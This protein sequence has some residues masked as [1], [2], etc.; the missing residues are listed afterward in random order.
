MAYER[1]LRMNRGSLPVLTAAWLFLASSCSSV[2]PA[3]IG[4][5]PD[6]A[7]TPEQPHG[8]AIGH[9]P[10][11]LGK[12]ELPRI[13]VAADGRSFESSDGHP[14]VPFGVTY[15][16]PGTGWA[17]QVWKQFD[18]DA[19]RRDFA[20]MKRL[21]VNCVRV[22][23]TYGSFYRKP[24]ELDQSGLA[25]FD[26]LL[27]IAEQAGI[28]IHPTGPDHWEG[29][30]DWAQGDRIA[31]EGKLQALES[32][33]RLFAAKYQGRSVIFAY[34][35]LNEPAV[36]WDSEAMRKKWPGWLE[37]KHVSSEALAAAHGHTGLTFATAPIPGGT[38][39]LGDRALLDFQEFRESLADD[40]TA[41]QVGAIRSVDRS[42]LVTVGLIQWSVP[43][44][45]ASPKHYSGFR[46]ARQA[47][48]LD[49]LE[50]HFYPF[51]H[52]AYEYGDDESE[53]RNL[54]Y[55]DSVVREVARPGKPVVL[56]EFGW[57]GGGRPRFD[58]G[59]HPAATEEQQARWCRKVI[60]GTR[61]LA[62]G[63]LTWGL[64]DQPEATDVSEFTGL[65][66]GDGGMKAWG[67]EF[68]ELAAELKR[69]PFQPSKPVDYPALNWDACLT[70]SDAGKTFRER[71][72]RTFV[73]VD[74]P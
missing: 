13:R 60:R 16:R 39:A 20:L 6:D 35:L 11:R 63:W 68:R 1:A 45:L 36:G 7:V 43:V 74:L 37:R 29:L 65:I 31:D 4:S 49:F 54:S 26:Q 73:E 41:R 25:K 34:D 50:V 19:T 59:R 56:A 71:Y 70:S 66:S 17:P 22:F 14:F 55:L 33:W 57:Y 62:S 42:A 5:P 46:P 52:G 61:G 38:N 32:F 51:E 47:R 64:Y 18:A 67:R 48:L 23:L 15:Y 12:P 72:L 24:G 3:R 21:G 69:S 44:L 58:E 8:L 2:G 28:Y 27:A 53:R 10:F 30:P 9:I 40:W